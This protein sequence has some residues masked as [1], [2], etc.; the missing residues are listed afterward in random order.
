METEEEKLPPHQNLMTIALNNF[1]LQYKKSTDLNRVN[2]QLSAFIEKRE[3]PQNLSAFASELSAFYDELLL[4]YNDIC[5]GTLS[6]NEILD[7]LNHISLNFVG[8]DIH[9]D[10]PLHT[11]SQLEKSDKAAPTQNTVVP[12]GNPNVRVVAPLKTSVTAETP[13]AEKLKVDVQP[14]VT[15]PTSTSTVVEDNRFSFTRDDGSKVTVEVLD[16]VKNVYYSTLSRYKITQTFPNLPHGSNIEVVT[17][18]ATAIDL[19]TLQTSPEYKAM[20]K[21]ALSAQNIYDA[22]ANHSTLLYKGIPAFNQSD[23]KMLDFTEDQLEKKRLDAAPPFNSHDYSYE[24][25]IPICE[26]HTPSPL[27]DITQYEYSVSNTRLSQP[28]LK[29][30]Y[31]NIELKKLLSDCETFDS[32]YKEFILA[33]IAEFNNDSTTDRSFF[34]INEPN[35]PRNYSTVSDSVIHEFLEAYNQYVSSVQFSTDDSNP[36]DNR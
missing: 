33:Q 8:R 28:S 24:R 14:T 5:N 32:R 19:K 31:S 34:M 25:L 36:G 30:I 22:T 12:K 3:I 1:F 20:L 18:V 17:T 2:K 35:I 21:T 7:K 6:S 10:W 27:P 15:P 13:L 11:T 23:K 29:Y 16:H 26:F 9:F 4:L